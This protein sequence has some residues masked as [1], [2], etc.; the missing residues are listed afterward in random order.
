M[1]SCFIPLEN[2]VLNNYRSF[3]KLIRIGPNSFM[4]LT[5]K[6]WGRLKFATSYSVPFTGAGATGGK[7][8]P[9]EVGGNIHFLL[10]AYNSIGG[11]VF[12]L[13]TLII[14]PERW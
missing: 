10:N 13:S 11:M 14:S 7:L 3:C 5:S 6:K 8:F 2:Q 12:T 9:T 1:A 4:S